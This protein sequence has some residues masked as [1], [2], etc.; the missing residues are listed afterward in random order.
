MDVKTLQA[1]LGWDDL[2]VEM[3]IKTVGRTTTPPTTTAMSSF[4]IGSKP[5][6]LM[7]MAMVTILDRIVVLRHLT[8]T[9]PMVICSRSIL[10]NTLIT[11]V[12]AG[13]ITNQTP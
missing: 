3:M 2:V 11:M 6:I 8:P 12:M 4:S 13:A 7:V 5:K 9:T 1:V 10:H